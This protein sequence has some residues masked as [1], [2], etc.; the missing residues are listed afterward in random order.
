M[1]EH[2]HLN[3]LQHVWVKNPIY[4]ITT[5]VAKRRPLLANDMAHSILRDEWQGLSLRHGWEAGRYVVMPDHAHFFLRPFRNEAKPLS[6]MIGLWKEWT[7]KRL[8]HA[9]GQPAPLWQPEFFDHVVRSK[10]AL[11]GKW[12]YVR[13]NPVR[14]GLVAR[15]EDWP[16][17]GSVDFW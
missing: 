9:L 17:A 14:A 15:A 1:T 12:A 2:K 13:E 7:A 8:L 5:C 10:K 6:E 3:R 11:L 16:Y 4:F